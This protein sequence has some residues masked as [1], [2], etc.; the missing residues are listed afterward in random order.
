M[1]KKQLKEKI[2]ETSNDYTHLEDE[3][4][5]KFKDH[6]LHGVRDNY[7]VENCSFIIPT[8][9]NAKKAINLIEELN[10]IPNI[11]NSEIILLNDNSTNR[12]SK[13]LSNYLTRYTNKFYLRY[14]I[15][16]KNQGRSY[17]KN[18]G[19]MEA[20]YDNV[21]AVDADM[22]IKAI[23]LAELAFK[24]TNTKQAVLLGFK[25]DL[26]ENLNIEPSFRNDWRYEVFPTK[27]FLNLSIHGKEP[28][29]RKYNI[30]QETNNL[31]DFG[32]G[33]QLGFWDLPCLVIGHTL[34]F[35]RDDAIKVGGFPETFKTWGLEDIAFGAKMI[36]ANNKIIPIKSVVS[37][38]LI[39]G[40]NKS[41]ENNLTKY[42]ALL[43]KSSIRPI[44]QRVIKTSFSNK[45][46]ERCLVNE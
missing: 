23:K 28:I 24:T 38:H 13:E 6:L 29:L 33:K 32:F 37:K 46:Y 19:I 26:K 7:P 1:K 39:H 3:Y 10:K 40:E 15:N 18:T 42:K 41:V 12:Y 4:A 11:K 21:I 14:L 27:E 30:L 5:L 43:E 45:Y 25:M 16:E 20:K 31:K 22:D 2:L 9:N 36:S 8:Y 34:G 44:K 35:K 17:T